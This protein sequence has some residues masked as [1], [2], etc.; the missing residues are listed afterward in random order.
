MEIEQIRQL[1]EAKFEGDH[2]R[3]ARMNHFV[4]MLRDAVDGLAVTGVVIKCEPLGLDGSPL[5]SKPY[6]LESLETAIKTMQE[7]SRAINK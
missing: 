1:L 2:A 7:A 5:P 4:N 3:T 6:A